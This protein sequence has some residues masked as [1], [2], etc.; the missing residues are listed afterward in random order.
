MLLCAVPMACAQGYKA[1]SVEISADKVRRGGRIFY[2]HIVKEKQTLYSI[3]RK[4]GISTQDIIDCNPTLN[5]SVNQIKAGDV[6]FIPSF[7]EERKAAEKE[8]REAAEELQLALE[9][10]GQAAPADTAAA[11]TAES[12]GT[13]ESPEGTAEPAL[14]PDFVRDIPKT[15]EVAVLL[16]FNADSVKHGTHYINFY[17]GAL[18]AARDLGN[19][20]VKMNVTAV[21]VCDAN[22]LSTVGHILKKSNVIIGPVSPAFIETILEKLPEDKWLV[23]PLDPKTEKFTEDRHVI[24]APTPI[25]AQIADMAEWVKEDMAQ[26]PSDS[27]IVVSEEGRRMEM[28]DTTEVP[29]AM[30]ISYSMSEGLEM[31]EYFN[32]HTHLGDT[33]TR[34]LVASERDVFAKDVVRNA[35]L[36][37]YKMKNVI[38][39]GNSKMKSSEMEELCDAHVHQST[40]YFIDY[41][42]AEVRNFIKDFRA[43]YDNDPDNFAFH[44]YD[45]FKFFVGAC[46]E[47]GVNWPQA[48]PVIKGKGLQTDFDF[49][50]PCGGKG[51]VNSAVRRVIYA[52]GLQVVTF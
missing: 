40:T 34:V 23:S 1:A 4:Y 36:Q 3:A 7:D 46:A 6:L 28:I 35:D 38:V 41:E 19:A 37:N 18:L 30:H 20:G 52:P 29:T 25:S 2:A 42:S 43:L 14:S 47:Y 45:T 17:M 22:A 48:L 21:D 9:I 8:A 26:N 24:L 32:A 12:A 27:V 15:I 13:A 11:A 31:Q 33:L 39:Y 50:R 10:T 5:L 51:A 16:P 44:G 49:S